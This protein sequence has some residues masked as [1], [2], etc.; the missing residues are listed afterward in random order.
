MGKY[1]TS[2]AFVLPSLISF[3][4]SLTNQNRSHPE[5]VFFVFASVPPAVSKRVSLADKFRVQRNVKDHARK[6]RRLAKAN[7]HVMRRAKKQDPGIPNL[8]P[9]KE[10]MLRDAQNELSAAEQAR[11]AERATRTERYEKNKLR[12]EEQTRAVENEYKNLNTPEGKRKWYFRELL[13]VVETADVILEV[14]DARDPVGCRAL[15]IER[16][17]LAQ[18]NADGSPSKKLVLV[19]NKIDM[20]PPEV[21]EAWTRYLRREFPTI[22]FKSST[23]NGKGFLQSLDVKATKAGSKALES[24]ASV[25][26][27]ALLQLLKNYSRSLGAKKGITVG[28]IGYPNVGKSS[29]INSLKMSRAVQVSAAAGCTKTLQQV[30]LDANIMLVDSPGVLFAADDEGV[31]SSASGDALA[32]EETRAK[33]Q[34]L[35]LR[36]VLRADQI[37]DPTVAVEGILARC[38]RE[39]LMS[40]YQVAEFTSGR[41]FLFFLA[42]RLGK[43]GKGGIPNLD[44]AAR[45]V[46][47]DWNSGKIPFYTLPPQVDDVAESSI[48]SGFAESFD[49]AALL[50]EA[51]KDTL[52]TVERQRSMTG[53]NEGGAMGGESDEEFEADEEDDEAV[54]S[55]KAMLGAVKPIV[56][57]GSTAISASSLIVEESDE[58]AGDE[59]EGHLASAV[60]AA[61]RGMAGASGMDDEDEAEEEDIL[62]QIAPNAFSRVG[63]GAGKAEKAFSVA[64]A[65]K[66]VTEAMSKVMQHS[67]RTG[68][69]KIYK[70]LNDEAYDESPVN[71]AKNNKAALKKAKKDQRR[72]AAAGGAGMDDDDDG[73]NYNFSTDY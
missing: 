47:K 53:A 5:F 2:I 72:M 45:V 63:K 73:D 35:L 71:V 32:D 37:E 68:R 28:V 58:E 13:K 8:W 27:Q 51:N 49:I 48:V 59:D 6:M 66:P 24:R 14:L 19:L 43:I 1:G 23:H 44:D 61:K 20:V 26:G 65:A 69:S 55:L 52:A 15:D 60:S 31:A 36:N 40:I 42:H 21:V 64:R 33:T 16:R 11:A 41:E 50:D 17:V 70:I 46:L 56:Q 9:H 10:S 38:S 54:S 22:A 57:R 12:Y 39:Q 29:I 34:S 7:P 3:P 67:A 18:Q 62:K 30:R 25:G 4:S